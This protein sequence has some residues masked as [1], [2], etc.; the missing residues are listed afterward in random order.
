MTR[1]HMSAGAVV[2][3]EPPLGVDAQAVSPHPPGPERSTARVRAIPPARPMPRWLKTVARAEAMLLVGALGL[4]GV[5]V[6]A[7]WRASLEPGPPVPGVTIGGRPVADLPADAVRVEAELAAIARL[8]RPLVLAAGAAEVTTTAQALGAQPDASGAAAAALAVGRTGDPIADTIARVRAATQGFDVPV[9]ARLQEDLALATLLGLA[10][11][12]DRPS[13]ATRL[14]LEARK[15]VPAATGSA[16][17][18]YDSLSAVAIGLARGADRI[19]L[20]VQDKAP[21]DGDPLAQWAGTLDVSVTL[22]SFETPY[23]MDAKEADRNHNLK[24]GAARLSAT[25]IGPGETFSFNDTVGDRSAENGFRYGGGIT[26]GELV[27]VLGGGICQVSSTLYGAAFFAG[28]EVVEHR[29]HSR[30]SAYVDMGLDSTV[31]WPDVDLRLRNPFDFPVVLHMTVSQGRVHA[32]VLGPR[33]PV[34]VAFERTLDEVVPFE[35]IVRADDRLRTGAQ[36]VAQRGM[37]G[38]KIKRV[39]KVLQA[40][41]VVREET[42]ELTYPPTVEIVRR[43]TNPS[44]ELPE[45]K[46]SAALRD[47][48]PFLRIV[49]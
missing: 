9:G 40:G 22:G 32:E 7:S 43:G 3:R 42:S 35:T 34:Q 10:P 13:S 28:L 6:H 29:P 15:V 12:V 11:A 45:A 27:D 41:E 37:R 4:A 39:R 19:D 25:V 46:P 49:Q 23:A 5:R 20:V 21:L 36:V 30:P 44:G 31:V 2:L 8:S 48:A 38:F 1:A 17:L 47:P 24:A 16:L 26:A 14:D 33:R 18:P